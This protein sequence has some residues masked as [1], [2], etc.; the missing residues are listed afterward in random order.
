MTAITP[1]PSPSARWKPQA[2]AQTAFVDSPVFEVVYGGAR[3]SG[4]TEL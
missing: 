4:K 1:I 3:G 2:G